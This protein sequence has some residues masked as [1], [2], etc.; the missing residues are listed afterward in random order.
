MP[1]QSGA[2]AG[3]ANSLGL[4]RVHPCGVAEVIFKDGLNGGLQ[5]RIDP[6]KFARTRT[7]NPLPDPKRP[8]LGIPSQISFGRIYVVNDARVR[9]GA[10]AKKP[11]IIRPMVSLHGPRAIDGEGISVPRDNVLNDQAS[12]SQ[13]AKLGLIVFRRRLHGLLPNW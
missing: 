9:F 8:T 12:R 2:T 3:S 7:G 5:R 11:L 4:F 1:P 6:L 10:F 13:R